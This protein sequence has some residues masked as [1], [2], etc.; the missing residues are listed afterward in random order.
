MTGLAAPV[1][2]YRGASVPP[3]LDDATLHPVRLR[4]PIINVDAPVESVGLG[5]DGAMGVPS[6]PDKVAWYNLG[7]VPGNLGNAVIDGHVD[8]RTGPAV[9]W[10]VRKLNPGDTVEVTLSDGRNLTFD[11]KQVVRY[12]E[13]DAPIDQIFGPSTEPNLNL[14]TCGGYFDHTTRKYDQRLVVYT[15]LH[16]Q[17]QDTLRLLGKSLTSQVVRNGYPAQYYEKAV[18]EDHASDAGIGPNSPYRY[19]YG[20]LVDQL[21]QAQVNLPIGGD[22]SSLTYAGLHIYADKS[23]LVPPPPGYTGNVYKYPDGTVFIPFTADLSAGPGH[24]IWPQ[25][26]PYMNRRDLFPGGWLN[27]IGLP[28]TQPIQAKVTKNFATGPVE[29]TIIV[30]AFQRTILTYDPANPPDWQVERANIGTDYYVKAG[31]R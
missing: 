17:Q 28:I 8:S 23:N 27:D 6:G 1:T 20:L 15:T 4:L 19:Q 12:A 22:V 26:W 14:I 2:E 25:F 11:V 24:T 5:S 3:L 13:N 31:L 18:V 9:F 16:V 30:Q 7:A 21:H 10:D 29:R